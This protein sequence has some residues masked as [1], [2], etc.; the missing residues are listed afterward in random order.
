MLGVQYP[1]IPDRSLDLVEMR[2]RTPGYRTNPSDTV[3]CQVVY[4]LGCW[5]FGAIPVSRTKIHIFTSTPF[6]GPTPRSASPQRYPAIR[7]A[8]DAGLSHEPER[9][10][11]LLSSLCAGASFFGAVPVPH[12]KIQIFKPAPIG[13]PTAQIESPRRDLAIQR[14]RGWDR[15]G[16][17]AK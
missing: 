2:S 15:P 17:T 13:G 14:G 10:R 11:V 3:H 1:E 12:T 8:E 7:T 16:I 6:K 9:H 5:F 4:A